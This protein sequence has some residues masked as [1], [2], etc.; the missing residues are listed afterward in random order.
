MTDDVIKLI[1]SVYTFDSYGNQ[2]ETATERVVFCKVRSVGRSEFYQAAQNNLHPEY[3]FILSHFMDYQGEPELAYTD[4]TGT[5]KRY[6]VIRTYRPGDSDEIEI[7][8]QERIGNVNVTNGS[9]A[10]D[11]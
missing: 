7:T 3:T 4:Y 6:D 11:S 9:D 2:V 10:E 5:T 8:A 1:N